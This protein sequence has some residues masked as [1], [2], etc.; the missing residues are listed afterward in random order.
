[1]KRSKKPVNAWHPEQ[2]VVTEIAVLQL[3]SSS[4][5]LSVNKS[6]LQKFGP[7][8][9]IWLSF[10]ID[11][12]LY[13][14]Q[15]NKIKDNWFYFI[16]ANQIEKMGITEYGIKKCKTMFSDLGIIKTKY[17]GL[18]K[19]EWY[20]I[21]T[22]K[23]AEVMGIAGIDPLISEGQDPLI[24]EGYYKSIN[25]L[26]K[27]TKERKPNNINNA[28]LDIEETETPSQF[29]KRVL[30]EFD[31]FWEYYPRK[32]S[33]QS[34]RNR[35]LKIFMNEKTNK[36][37]PEAPTFQE[38]IKAIKVQSPILAKRE[39]KF[40]P[41]ASTWL[42]EARWEDNPKDLDTGSTN[43]KSKKSL[44]YRNP[45]GYQYKEAEEIV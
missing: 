30:Q 2:L 38:V 14:K 21:N 41:H 20:S 34:S 31:N 26:N 3:F 18:P 45:E 19:K 37:N 40:I 33:K 27:E 25:R 39:T 8:P 11:R 36:P 23:L 9:A 24:S 7:E 35:W 22:N 1:M 17:A 43:D 10:L 28:L 42:N 4:S 44:G 12:F 32:V 13:L 15:S 29:K 16:H 5:F 6:L